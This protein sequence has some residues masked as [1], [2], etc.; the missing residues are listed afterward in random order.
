MAGWI[1]LSALLVVVFVAWFI[2]VLAGAARR[3]RLEAVSPRRGRGRGAGS[4]LA[5]GTRDVTRRLGTR[6]PVTDT[7]FSTETFIPPEAKAGGT[8]GGADRKN[9]S[10]RTKRPPPKR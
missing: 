10:S 3:D 7:E 4:R 8:R 1:W 9:A 5:A 6:S 2:I